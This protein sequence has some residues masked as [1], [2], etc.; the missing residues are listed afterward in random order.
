MFP[1]TRPLPEA[2]Q[3]RAI[4]LTR[5]TNGKPRAKCDNGLLLAAAPGGLRLRGYFNRVSLLIT[6]SSVRF[7][8]AATNP[9][10]CGMAMCCSNAFSL[11]QFS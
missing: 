7:P 10:K 4:P 6:I 2:A 11:F 9:W 1:H 5:T 8:V 3:P